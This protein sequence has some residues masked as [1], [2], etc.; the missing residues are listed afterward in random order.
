MIVLGPYGTTPCML[1]APLCHGLYFF[2]VSVYPIVTVFSPN[3]LDMNTSSCVA[4]S[5]LYTLTRLVADLPWAALGRCPTQSYIDLLEV[6]LQRAA[7]S[8]APVKTRL[9]LIAGAHAQ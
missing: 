2:L 7:L 6:K 9:D 5:A 3:V 1:H 8:R 4:S